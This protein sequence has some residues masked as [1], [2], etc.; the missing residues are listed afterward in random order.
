MAKQVKVNP[1]DQPQAFSYGT[2]DSNAR[3]IFQ[4]RQKYES[5]IFPDFL[6]PNF[7]NSWKQDRFY[8]LVN[9]KGN[10]TIPLRQALAPLYASEDS[11]NPQ[12][13]L[14]FVAD[15]WRDFVLRVR[16]LTATNIIFE[17]SPWATPRAVKGY[18]PLKTIYN[19]YMGEDVY[20]TFYSGFVGEGG[21]NNKI[22]NLET[23]L[24]QFDIYAREV[25]LKVG[26]LTLSGMVESNLSPFYSSGLVIE[27]AH[28]EYD[29]DFEKAYEFGDRNFSFIASIAA[30]YGFAVDKNIPWR[31]IA[32]IRN[33]AM[34]EYMRGVDIVG[35]DIAVPDE[36]DCE[37]I[38]QDP[39]NPPRAFGF[40]GIPG[41]EDV[42]RRI[43][44]YFEEGS[45][46][47]TP[48]YRQYNST[49]YTIKNKPQKDV[50]ERMYSTD[51]VATWERDMDLLADFLFTFYN[52]FVE[53]R[54]NAVYK[55]LKISELC[56]VA[57]ITITRTPVTREEFD[58]VCG[59]LWKLKNF[60]VIRMAE[61]GVMPTAHRRVHDI[62]QIVNIYNM[63]RALEAQGAYEIALRNAQDDFVGPYDTD[64]LTLSA[65]RDILKPKP[66]QL[67]KPTGWVTR[68]QQGQTIDTRTHELHYA[69]TFSGDR[70]GATD[71]YATTTFN[72]DTYSLW[73]GFTISFWVRPDERMNHTAVIL[74]SKSNNP[75]EAR[76]KFGVH[77]NG[78][79]NVGIG[80]VNTT[81][82]RNPMEVG[83][84]YN[85]V[86]SYTGDDKGYGERK[87][88]M[89]INNDP[90]MTIND[91]TRWTN[92]D[93]DQTIYFGGRNTEGAYS[94]GFACALTNVAIYN[95]CKD[96][97]GTFANQVYNNGIK[98]NYNGS[99]DL[100]G[101][102]RFSEGRGITIA[103][104][105]GNGNN[106]TFGAIS[107]Q[108]TAYPI[109]EK[110]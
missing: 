88:R 73:N 35:F 40:S 68:T 58:N 102:W 25:V 42:T 28:G 14:G 7:M 51:F 85:W 20:A 29:Q 23:F 84:W 77:T 57:P 17:N 8:G 44:F 67:F 39:E 54:P 5:Y 12:F 83:Q 66:V 89:W 32:D 6:A 107:G 61:R 69:L 79:I 15:A 100:V 93:E 10:A 13:A 97:D 76:F 24:E 1:Q 71:S 87:V 56:T 106:G 90:R 101:Y 3:I 72:P 30:Q 41:L 19:S 38:I 80:N 27:M 82:I 103:D 59:S 37:P 109:W 9:T 92:Q 70:A 75:S 104:T 63:S 65:V 2:N 96:S 62:Q 22:S 108:T 95:V 18:A 55:P 60:Y 105:S 43:H 45:E 52:S 81:G 16:E 74:G 110:L 94:Q 31:L 21:I 86:I 99:D 64:P 46:T 53:Q 11:S 36:F 50:F 33:P 26:P 49:Q 48:G 34:Q 47:A 4:E 78:N 98:H 91:N